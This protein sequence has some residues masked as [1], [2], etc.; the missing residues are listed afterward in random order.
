[1]KQQITPT[2]QVFEKDQYVKVIKP[3]FTELTVGVGIS[4]TAETQTTV[5]VTIPEFF[6]TYQDLF[7][8]IPKEGEFNSHQFIINQSSEYAQGQATNQQILALTQEIKNLRQENLEL[9]QQLLSLTKIQ[10]NA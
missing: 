4:T 2:L 10:T 5:P 1:M 8:E 7:F 6:E 9:Q 3:T